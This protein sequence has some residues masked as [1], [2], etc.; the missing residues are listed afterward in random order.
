M[1]GRLIQ[2]WA[3]LE[4][5]HDG[6]GGSGVYEFRWSVSNFLSYARNH[7]VLMPHQQFP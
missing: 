3:Y 7:H 6:S 5:E 4:E 1:L 2:H